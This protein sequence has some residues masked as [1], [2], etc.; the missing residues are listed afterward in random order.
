[1]CLLANHSLVLLRFD[2]TLSKMKM[3]A[4]FQ[5]MKELI[6]LVILFYLYF[7]LP[8]V[9]PSV[10][11][12]LILL[13]YI[14]I[15]QHFYVPRLGLLLCSSDFCFYFLCILLKKCFILS[16]YKLSQSIGE[17]YTILRIL[18]CVGFIL[19]LCLVLSSWSSVVK[20]FFITFICW[21]GL[22]LLCM[23]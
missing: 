6:F 18:F 10:S 13:F 8:S 2:L 21:S 22:L 3:A 14:I 9:L 19:T 15:S 17:T 11:K 5:Y 4:G 16:F 23:L 7:V 12:L 1:V 20:F